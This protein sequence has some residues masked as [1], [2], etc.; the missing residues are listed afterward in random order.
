MSKH[1]DKHSSEAYIIWH[2][3]HK[4]GYP[5]DSEEGLKRYENFRKNHEL[6]LKHNAD[7]TKSYKLALN[8]FADNTVHE[9]REKLLAGN[10]EAFK[11]KKQTNEYN[12]FSEFWN[13]PEEEDEAFYELYLTPK[14]RLLT[15]VNFENIDWI[16]KANIKYIE[17][18]EECGSCWAFA[19][20]QAVQAEYFIKKGKSL[21]FS[22]QQLVDCETESKGCS[23][24]SLDGALDYI[25]K[26]GIVTEDDYPYL[27]EQKQCSFK[28]EKI[29]TKIKSW[30]GCV[31]DD[32]PDSKEKCQT[33]QGLYSQLV[34]GPVSTNVD[35]SE[36]FMLYDSGIY[37]KECK[38]GNHAVLLVGYHKGDSNDSHW[39]IKNSWGKAWGENGFGKI[40]H[41]KDYNNCLLHT[42]YARP[43]IE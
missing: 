42:Y 12:K 30:E 10:L 15:S 14:P 7:E 21:R 34:K 4:K 5:I 31:Q 17:D 37:D 6:V 1:M 11:N 35:A 27:G 36:E 9:F 28:K 20:A 8:H 38:E 24:G 3:V 39:V 33:E 41:S 43:N 19:T 40:K 25:K 18:Q 16:E 22:K 2:F 29:I 23:G 32:K 26:N 13:L